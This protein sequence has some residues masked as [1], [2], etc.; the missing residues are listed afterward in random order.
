MKNKNYN[1]FVAYL[2][3]LQM[4]PKSMPGLEKIKKA[5]DLTDWYPNINPEKVIVIAGTNGKGK[6]IRV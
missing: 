5:L 1:E 4:M 3:S 6:D 2:E